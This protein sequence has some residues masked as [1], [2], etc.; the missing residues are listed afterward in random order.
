MSKKNNKRK[1]AQTKKPKKGNP[2]KTYN[3]PIWGRLS[4]ED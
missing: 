2:I 3:H 4:N 1:K